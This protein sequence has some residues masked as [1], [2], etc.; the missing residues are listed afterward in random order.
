[1]KVSAYTFNSTYHPQEDQHPSMPSLRLLEGGKFLP[2]QFAPVL[3]EDEGYPRLRYFKWGMPI[4]WARKSTDSRKFVSLDTCKTDRGM[5]MAIREHRCLIPADGFYVESFNMPHKQYKLNRED[6][7]N[8]CFAGVYQS[9]VSPDGT[10]SHSFALLSKTESSTFGKTSLQMPVIVP[11][12]LEKLWLNSL[13][14]LQK[15]ETVL[16]LT[17]MPKL[18]WL[19]VIE[20]K[21]SI[22]VNSH[23]L[24]A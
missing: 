23:E 19:P 11:R 16:E 15:I 13:T 6:E 18:S 4:A 9:F 17:S 1:M 10:L 3:I 7:A 8:F 14:P 20:L 5:Q 12:R 22:E 21:P 2:N 24:A